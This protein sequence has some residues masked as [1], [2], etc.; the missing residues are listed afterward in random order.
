MPPARLSFLLGL[1]MLGC[2]PA[3][4]QDAQ[5]WNGA[6]DCRIAAVKPDA[7]KPPSWSGGCKD[8]YAEGKGVLEW[9][10]GT[11]DA[12]RLSATLRAGAI[13]GEGELRFPDGGNYTGTFRDGVPEGHGYYRD[14][15]G[16]QFEGEVHA[17]RFSGPGE[18]LYAMGNDYKGELKDNRPDGVGTMTYIL[19]GRYEGHWKDGKRNGSGKLVYAGLPMREVATIDGR[20]PNRHGI[21]PTKTY[22]LKEESARTGSRIALDAARGSPVPPE[23]GYGE[24]SAEQRAIVDSWYPALAPGDEPPYPLHGPAEFYRFASAVAGKT[25]TRGDIR[26]YVLVSKDGKVAGVRASGLDDADVRKALSTGAGAIAYKPARCAGQ[27]CEM[28]YG[29]S[30][31]LTLEP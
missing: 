11:G 29:Y 21:V 14:A 18:V 27:P 3:L 28:A 12:F 19:G 26:I 25:R 23:L 15:K 2:R 1:A 10:T 24:L 9:R 20:D 31:S 7:A 8:G 16:N 5:A 30:F 13:Q 4:A 6:P 22:T 17:G